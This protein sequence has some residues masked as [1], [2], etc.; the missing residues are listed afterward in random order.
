MESLKAGCFYTIME[1]RDVQNVFISY[2]R[3]FTLLHLVLS[4]AV[5][6]HSFSPISIQDD[7][8]ALPVA[9]FCLH[10]YLIPEK[11]I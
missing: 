5:T 2:R 9:S 1:V 10:Q 4:V 3:G 8:A 6:H 11:Q 7:Q